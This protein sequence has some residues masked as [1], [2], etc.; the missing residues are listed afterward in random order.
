VFYE[1]SET[2]THNQR[3][4]RSNCLVSSWKSKIKSKLCDDSICSREQG[5]LHE[6]AAS[7]LL[8]M[9]A[10]A[11]HLF[12]HLQLIWAEASGLHLEEYSEPKP[13]ALNHSQV[14]AGEGVLHSLLLEV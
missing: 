14:G 8:S 6:L 5:G 1:V 2:S 9:A 7:W 10:L 3:A 13:P 4:L 12:H 11:S